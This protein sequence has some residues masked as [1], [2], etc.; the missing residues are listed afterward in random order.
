MTADTPDELRYTASHEWVADRGEGTVR[1][2]ITNYAQDA[3][4]DLVY[5]ALP[6]AGADVAAEQPCGE[7]ESTK[8]VSDLNSPVTGKVSAVNDALTDTP[9]LVNSEPYGGGWLFEVEVTDPGQLATLL[10]AQQYQE[11]LR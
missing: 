4:G 6:E 10:S 5:V 9:E 11:R 8:S 2:G 3:L 1:I 7:L